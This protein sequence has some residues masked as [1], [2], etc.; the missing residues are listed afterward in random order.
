MN[1]SFYW[2]IAALV[3]FNIF[4]HLASKHTPAEVNAFAFLTITYIIA[5]VFSA[6]FYFFTNK[7]GNI[8]NHFQHINWATVV[9][10]IAIVGL[11]IGA[12]YMYKLGWNLNTGQI[13]YSSILAVALFLIGTLVYK[14]A[15]SV[16][17]IIGI[18]VCLFGI[19]LIN[20]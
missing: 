13:L 19:F 9:M 4:Y 10:S 17:K 12:I 18:A 15:F 1:I 5:A 6:I 3:I 7:E 14:E 11:E 2:P 8:F 20:R 16:S